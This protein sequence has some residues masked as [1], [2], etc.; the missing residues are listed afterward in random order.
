MVHEIYLDV[1]L[2]LRT[3]ENENQPKWSTIFF[4]IVV[5][6]KLHF[7]FSLYANL[8]LKFLCVCLLYVSVVYIDKFTYRIG[9]IDSW[10]Y[11]IQD[12]LID[13]NL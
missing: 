8:S 9:L 5:L 1:K 10:P 6:W 2:F 3:A 12:L 4:K 13:N 11:E 7:P